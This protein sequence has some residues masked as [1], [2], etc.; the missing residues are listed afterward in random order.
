MRPKTTD[1]VLDPA[2]EL[3][4]WILYNQMIL[5]KLVFKHDSNTVARPLQMFSEIFEKCHKKK[6]WTVFTVFKATEECVWTYFIV[7]TNTFIGCCEICGDTWL[8]FFFSFIYWLPAFF[9]ANK[10]FDNDDLLEVSVIM[11][12]KSFP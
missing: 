9:Q 1:T 2:S 5:L 8:N 10:S 11:T 12:C 3:C 7:T 6:R 4:Q